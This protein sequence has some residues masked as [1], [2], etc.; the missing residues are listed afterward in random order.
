M[1]PDESAVEVFYGARAL[2]PPPLGARVP[3]RRQK[4]AVR[5]LLAEVSARAPVGC[6]SVTEYQ[7]M[8]HS[9]RIVAAAI[10][11][12]GRVG[13]DVELMCP[14][15]NTGAILEVFLAPMDNPVSLSA[16]YRV[17][18]FGEAY[19]KAFG[20]LPGSEALSQVIDVHAGDGTSDGAYRVDCR[21]NGAAGV[22]HS[23]PFDDF[24]LTIVW[25]MPDIAGRAPPDYPLG[26]TPE[27]LVRRTMEID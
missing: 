22:L 9:R 17:W 24:A 3:R 4:E 1:V 7:S 19:F 10:G 14:R 12:G 16:F 2:A 23:V 21:K 18:T 15:R 27:C 8:S 13:I 26:R 6:S 20:R 25:E 5:Y 11:R